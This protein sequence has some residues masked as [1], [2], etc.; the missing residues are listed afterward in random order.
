MAVGNRQ[1]IGAYKNGKMG[2]MSFVFESLDTD[3]LEGHSG[4]IS[5]ALASC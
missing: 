3:E 2:I 5:G 4:W 1:G